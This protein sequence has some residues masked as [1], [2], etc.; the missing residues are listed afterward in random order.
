MRLT[1]RDIQKMKTEGK[2]ITMLTAYDAISARLSEAADVEMILVG[3]T[4]GMVVQGHDSTIP[5]TLDQMIY[6]AEIVSRVTEKSL[7]VGDM[8]F[9]WKSVV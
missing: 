7:I 5:V 2:P 3:D 9:M 6:H 8:P 1:I 4:L